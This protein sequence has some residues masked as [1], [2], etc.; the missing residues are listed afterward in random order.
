MY[1]RSHLFT[2]RGFRRVLNPPGMVAPYYDRLGFQKA[3]TSYML[4]W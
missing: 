2:D 4:E 1:R 3:G